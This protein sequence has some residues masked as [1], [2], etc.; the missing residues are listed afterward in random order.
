M[1]PDVARVVGR[2]CET[3]QC[4]GHQGEPDLG[5]VNCNGRGCMSCVFRSMHDACVDDCPACCGCPDCGGDADPSYT[6]DDL[7]AWLRS[8]SFLVDMRDEAFDEQSAPQWQVEVQ[9]W[10]GDHEH[11]WPWELVFTGGIHST[12]LAALEA[13]VLAVADRIKQGAK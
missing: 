9:R 7:L 11:E 6:V 2:W 13:A 3:C 5:C 1:N 8:N 12:L 10:R 4:T